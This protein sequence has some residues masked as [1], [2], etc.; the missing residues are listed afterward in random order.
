MINEAVGI[1][2]NGREVKI[3]HLRRDKYRLAVDYLESAV[4]TRDMD[5]E[6]RKKTE[7]GSEATL[8][9][10]EEDLFALKSAYETKAP[11]DKDAGYR[12][13]VDVIY[14]LLRKFAARRVKVAFNVPPSQVSYQDLDTHLDYNKNVFKGTLKKKI[15]QWKQGFNAIDNVSV[16]TRKDGTLCN[17]SSEVKEPPILDILEQLNTFFKGNLVLSLMDSNEVSL[18][19]LAG[20]SY[21]FR[22]GSQLTVIIEI[23]DRDGIQQ[24]YLHERRRH[25]NRFANYP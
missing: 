10:N 25:I 15:E 14:S 19:N 4:L 5:F 17:V 12:E 13:N 16:I 11:S 21:D 24:N 9:Q 8:L 3:A 20:N 1:A 6:L 23:G 18:V 7:G 22:D 2:I